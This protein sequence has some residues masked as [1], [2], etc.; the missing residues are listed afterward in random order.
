ML[1][2]DLVMAAAMSTISESK[3][4]DEWR[5]DVWLRR[6]HF[7]RERLILFNLILLAVWKTSLEGSQLLSK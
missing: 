5:E 2:P 6:T 1:P 7:L 4:Q 3:I